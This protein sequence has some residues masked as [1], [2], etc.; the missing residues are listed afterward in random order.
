MHVF[1]KRLLFLL[2]AVLLLLLSSFTYHRLSLQREKASLNPMGQMVSVNGHDMS[3]FVKGEGPQTLVFL[4]GAGTASPILDFKDL[5]DGLSKQYKIVVVERA[6]YGYSEDTSKSRDVSEVLSETRQAL[7]KAQVSGPYI[8]LSH[9]MASLETLLWQE[10]Y[11]SEIQAVIGLDWSLPESYSQLRM[12]SQILRM[13]RLGS[14]LGLLRYIPS[15]LYVPNENL[16]S[17]DRRLYQRIAY[18]QILSQ[19]MLNESL[20]VEENAK[21]VDAKINSQIPTLLLVSNGE[22]TSFSKEEWRNY[23]ARFAKDQKNIELT[24]YDAPHYLY[25]YQTKEVVAKIE[26]FIKGTTD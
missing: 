3:V 7:A 12:H 14:Q 26:E 4:S 23:A 8:I 19:A 17:S 1:R 10:K 2:G 11:P 25:H 24:F 21:K 16:S 15:R 5:Y 20:S 13:A 9:S 18:R 6:G 22:G